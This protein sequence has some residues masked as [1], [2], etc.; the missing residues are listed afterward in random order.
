MDPSI[1]NIHNDQHNK[2]IDYDKTKKQDDNKIVNFGTLS[3]PVVQSTDE[4]SFYF[5]DTVTANEEFKRKSSLS[6]NNTTSETLNQLIISSVPQSCNETD[7][8]EILYAR[9]EGLYAHGHKKE[10]CKLV[11]ELAIELME[12]PPELIVDLPKNSKREPISLCFASGSGTSSSLEPENEVKLQSSSGSIST[13]TQVR[14]TTP[15]SSTLIQDKVKRKRNFNQIHSEHH[16]VTC[17]A[18]ETLKK[19][20]FFATV[21]MESKQNRSL[22]FRIA[23]F[24]LELNRLPASTKLLEVKL[25][26]QE[27]E[28][29]TL[30]KNTHLSVDEV[31]VLLNKAID[32]QNGLI[33]RQTL[34]LFNLAHLIFDVLVVIPKTTDKYT[35]ND[36]FII[37]NTE[38]EKIAFGAVIYALNLKT[39]VSE[40]EHPLLCES[41]RRQ[42]GE[43]SMAMLLHYKNDQWKL[44]EVMDKLLDKDVHQLSRFPLIAAYYSNNPPTCSQSDRLKKYHIKNSTIQTNNDNDTM[45]TATNNNTNNNNLLEKK[46]KWNRIDD[47][48]LS[49]KQIPIP[50][51][52]PIPIPIP[53]AIPINKPK[54]VRCNKES[55]FKKIYPTVPNQPSEASAHFMF[56]LAKN[57]LFKAGGNSTITLFT[58]SAGQGI[59][60]MS[61][62]RGLL[63][64]SLQ[65]GLYAL[66]LHNCVSPNWFNRTYS[67]Y[68]T[69]ITGQSL[70]IGPAAIAFIIDCW[71]RHLT[72]SE[73]LS[74]ADRASRACDTLLIKSSSQLALSCLKHAYAL[75]QQEIY[76]A[77]LLCKDQGNDILEEGCLIVENVARNS[78]V[79][80]DV[81]F[82]V[83]EYWFDMYTQSDSSKSND[84]NQSSQSDSELQEFITN[85]FH[86]HFNQHNSKT[87]P[88]SI[89]NTH[90]QKSSQYFSGVSVGGNGVGVGVGGAGAGANS[91][92]SSNCSL[93]NQFQLTGGGVGNIF[94]FENSNNVQYPF[95]VQNTPSIFPPTHTNCGQNF[96]SLLATNRTSSIFNNIKNYPTNTNGLISNEIS[97]FSHAYQYIPLQA[98]HHNHFHHHSYRHNHNHSHRN[99]HNC[100]HSSQYSQFDTIKQPSPI[101]TTAPTRIQTLRQ[102]TPRQ[103]KYLLSVYRVGL[104]A[105]ESL[106][107][108]IHEDSRL[109]SKFS[110]NPQYALAVI[111]HLRI[112]KYLGKLCKMI[113]EFYTEK[114][115]SLTI[116]YESRWMFLKIFFKENYSKKLKKD[117]KNG[118]KFRK[119]PQNNCF[120][121]KFMNLFLGDQYLQQ[122][123]QTALSTIS[124]PF[125][126]YDIA[127]ES[128]YYYSG[129]NSVL[130]SQHIQTTLLPLVQKCQQMFLQCLN[131]KIYHL[132]VD[133]F[134]EFFSAFEAAKNAFSLTSN[135]MNQLDDW[136]QAL[137]R[138]FFYIIS[139]T[140]KITLR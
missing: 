9:A 106:A 88:L 18:S 42:R 111:W 105:L 24:G 128:A 93:I 78:N 2:H 5:Y 104:L 49:L 67:S 77:L 21:L 79:N 64:C 123:T 32:L 102:L 25:A 10:A 91:N 112:S 80:A 14:T 30:I 36:T 54:L 94:S 84:S 22:A 27:T 119:S 16:R 3:D 140:D 87:L 118:E 89:L 63:M 38:N 108:K 34:L 92:T 96:P 99:N 50:L 115:E 97:S 60:N 40:A 98:K 71:E 53:I 48:A 132:G 59:A 95:A 31:S 100:Y 134:D 109:L 70:E 83:S 69:W 35:I 39:N 138:F 82:K 113:F 68:V 11:S 103:T 44:L 90:N 121:F 127:I 37:N 23:L 41:I 114:T 1:D 137:R 57:L 51:P 55:R 129:M 124:N 46:V 130:F 28:L 76:N 110:R 6:N 61:A 131:N 136:I 65:L 52:I 116:F 58:T 33:C 120:F 135:G 12:N 125:I 86:S 47:V 74:L 15:T 8:F 126:L 4:Y 75:N 20:Y 17:L 26:N 19:C 117:A 56:E 85:E 45:F 107:R 139:R 133:D 62:N 7:V 66:G 101:T 13:E 43:L 72:P 29:V 73:T 122:F 81:L